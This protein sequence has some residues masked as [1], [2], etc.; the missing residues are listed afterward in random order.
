[1]LASCKSPEELGDIIALYIKAFLKEWADLATLPPAKGGGQDG[2]CHELTIVEIL[3]W[4][5]GRLADCV[6]NLGDKI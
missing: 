2:Q 1:M 3:V 5:E 6:V 4:I